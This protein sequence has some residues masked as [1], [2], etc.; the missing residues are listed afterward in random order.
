MQMCSSVLQLNCVADSYHLHG[1]SS[2]RFKFSSC[3]SLLWDRAHR[4]RDNFQSSISGLID[5][6]SGEPHGWQL[7][8]VSSGTKI[9]CCHSLTSVMRLCPASAAFWQRFCCWWVLQD[10]DA[11]FWPLQL[12]TLMRLRMQVGQ[13]VQPQP[14]HNPTPTVNIGQAHS[15]NSRFT[16]ADT[17]FKH[18]WHSIKLFW[19]CFLWC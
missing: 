16:V 6:T 19:R 2:W 13:C 5:I 7:S 3:L 17:K 1:V 15:I 10:M 12:I 8:P 11:L 14:S 9:L 4:R 18:C